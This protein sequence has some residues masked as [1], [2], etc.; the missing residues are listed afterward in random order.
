MLPDTDIPLWV[1]S[2]HSR[3]LYANDRFRVESGHQ[4]SSNSEFSMAAFGQK[5]T[6]I[7]PIGETEI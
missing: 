3:I 7:Q 2:G 6:F 5:Q 4:I 1:I